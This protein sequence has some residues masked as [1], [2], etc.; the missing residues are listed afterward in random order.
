MERPGAPTLVL[1]TSQEQ[2]MSKQGFPYHS[3]ISRK[4]AGSHAICMHRLILPPGAKEKAHLH[5]NHETAIHIVS[6]R[7]EVLYGPELG[8]HLVVKQGEFLYIPPN[9]PHLPFNPSDNEPCVVLLSRT[10]PN[11]QESV[12]LLPELETKYEEFVMAE[13]A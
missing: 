7:A 4:T 6:G 8:E 1:N 9:V 3:G 10:D 5:R 11:E 2:Y 12:E 13:R